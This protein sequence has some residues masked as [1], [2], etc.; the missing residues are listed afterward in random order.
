M[1]DNE[2]YNK[3]I[4]FLKTIHAPRLKRCAINPDVYYPQVIDKLHGSAVWVYE[5]FCG[6]DRVL[7]ETG[8]IKG[9]AAR[10]AHILETT[11][12]RIR[13]IVGQHFKTKSYVNGL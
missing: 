3:Q 4:G 6:L 9:R 10:R 5:F 12:Y 2:Y 7:R 11:K 8:A 1:T 13:T